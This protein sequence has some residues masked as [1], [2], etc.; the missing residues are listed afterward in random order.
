MPTKIR[1]ALQLFITSVLCLSALTLTAQEVVPIRKDV[2]QHFFTFKQVEVL[3][4][5]AGK[6]TFE[7]V[8]SPQM[9][10]KF[11]ASERSTPQT[12]DLSTTL[13]MR[14]KIKHD[15]SVD[16]K[17]LLEF[18]DQ[19]IDHLDAYLPTGDG[20]YIRKSLG[21]GIKFDSREVHHKNFEL[22]LNNTDR[23]VHT[24]YFRI[25][26][27]QISDAIVVLRSV[28]RFISYALDEYFYFGIFYGMILVFSFYNL[29]MFIA[30]RQTQ[31]LHYVMYIL[32]V[33]LFEMS[34]DGIAFQYLWPNAV[35]WNQTAFSFA[36][37]SMSVF[38]LL[39]TREFLH[40]KRISIKLDRLILSV[41]FLRIAFLLFSYFYFPILLTYKFL[42]FI[43]LAVA[44]YAGIYVHRKGYVPA[45]FFVLGYS[46]LA[47]GFIIKVLIML[48]FEE[49]NQN[50]IGYYS[51][52]FCFVLEMIFLS[53]AIGDKVRI[54]R[55]KKERAQAE[56][57]HQMA[58]NAK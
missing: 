25:N 35:E 52:S 23:N 15:S 46:F 22:Y 4:D 7:Q 48:E 56:M 17:F 36:L 11:K 32:S 30:M 45:R 42:D 44:F 57:I 12:T 39:F 50:A 41:V 58:E 2:E 26:S 3:K 13:W 43:P 47:V 37:C 31:Y 16:R 18:F 21:D 1:F 53:F 9:Q 29:M 55:K 33:A 5:S 49:L 8:L 6:L 19:T 20:R 27:K 34:T 38:A 28:N 14:I 24:Y 40:V 51:L 54:L 10:A